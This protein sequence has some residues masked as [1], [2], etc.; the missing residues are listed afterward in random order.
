MNGTNGAADAAWIRTSSVDR[1]E[2]A[3]GAVGGAR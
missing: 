2:R 3:R 1:A